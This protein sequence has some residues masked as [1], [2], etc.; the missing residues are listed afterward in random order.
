MPK[1]VAWREGL[2]IRP[3][4]FQQNSYAVTTEMMRRASTAQ[5]NRWGLFDLKIDDQ[6][7]A[8]GKISLISA[9]G[10]LPDGTLF[11]TED[12]IEK[13][14]IEIVQEDSG[15]AI[16]LG[17]PLLYP[18]EDN[19]YFEEHTPLAT[20][21]RAKIENEIP[22]TNAGEESH[23]DI[24]FSYLNF[25]LLKEGE[26]REGFSCIQI[27]QVGNVTAN[28]TISLDE[29]FSPTY[30]H[31]HKAPSLSSKLNEL[32]GM[33]HYRAE[34]LAEKIEGG[35][36]QTTELGDYLILQLINRAEGRLHYFVTQENLH[37]GDLYLELV[38]LIGELAVFMKKEKR[39][40]QQFTYIHEKQGISFE[41]VFHE[42][43][44]LLSNVLESSSVR[45]PL[46]KH[47]YGISIAMLKEKSLL[48]NSSF[49][50]AASSNIDSTKL[51]K[52]L[53]DNLK[54]GTVE[55]IR[56]LVNH[57]LPGFKLTP[58]SSVPR[59]I[60]YR[61][62]QSYYRIMLDP[63]DIQKLHK[64][65]GMALHYPETPNLMIEFVLWSIK[66]K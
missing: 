58:L 11:D 35:T 19:I 32:Q 18:N 22:N 44:S 50:L 12:I 26:K 53:L 27:T 21:Y 61:V 56:N 1:N 66:T 28:N 63:K 15:K 41:T 25:K 2:F 8:Q 45:V 29:H 4:H 46:D 10:I 13:L 64:S 49:V 5:A 34:K 52:L 60:P 3:Q 40:L 39:L 36:L 17:L 9:S 16:Y 48:E 24:A 62:N 43:K 51:E 38:S 37:P 54:I 6:L 47:N 31:L 14:T 57:H 23:A 59:E 30:L 65:S 33:L 20:R 42:I 7:L 55:E